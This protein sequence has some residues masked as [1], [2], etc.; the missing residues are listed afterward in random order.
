MSEKFSMRRML[1]FSRLQLC[2]IYWSRP[3][4][5]LRICFA[6]ILLLVIFALLVEGGNLDE[7]IGFAENLLVVTALIQCLALGADLVTS[8]LLVPASML[9]K[10]I[11]IFFGTLCVGTVFLLVSGLLGSVIFSLISVVGP[12]MDGGVRLLFVGSAGFG[13]LAFAAF[14]PFFLWIE[15]FVAAR[16]R[17]GSW[18]VWGALAVAAT[19]ILLP[20]ILGSAGVIGERVAT[21]ISLTVYVIVAVMSLVWGYRLLL[22][23]ETDAKDN[24]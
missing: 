17:Y 2:E 22:V 18:P 11:S 16:R 6:V 23:F 15:L 8:R 3:W 4:K 10:Y 20:V 7:S 13:Y 12:G 1:L 19:G 21:V 5:T 14:L 24:D 9:E